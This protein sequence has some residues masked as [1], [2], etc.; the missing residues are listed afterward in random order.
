MKLVYTL[1][2]IEHYTTGFTMLKIHICTNV[3][4]IPDPYNLPCVT[5]STTLSLDIEI[6]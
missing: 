2:Q 5:F 6:T 3:H 1:Y 4:T